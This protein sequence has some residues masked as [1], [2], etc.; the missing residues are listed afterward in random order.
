[1]LEGIRAIG[2][3]LMDTVLADPFVPAIEEVTGLPVAEVYEGMDR[4][5][6][7]ALELGRIGD[8]EW[9]RRFWRPGSG[10]GPLDPAAFRRA[11]ST[12][13]RFLPGMEELL[14][15]LCRLRPLHVM[16]NYPR[17]YLELERRFALGR[18]FSGHHLSWE[19]GAR[20]PDPDYYRGVLARIG[21]APGELL[22]I[23]D[24]ERN[25]AAAAALGIRTLPFRGAHNL[26][27]LLLPPP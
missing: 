27:T 10:R 22:F 20:K 4:E 5:A 26:R 18:F 17:W 16:S 7:R 13:Y 9:G 6:W 15:E 2:F 14:G 25:L 12:R 24:R 8:E 1:M 21:V 11:A 23:D 3:D 19:V